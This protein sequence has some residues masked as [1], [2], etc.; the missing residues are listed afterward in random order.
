MGVLT[1]QWVLAYNGTFRGAIEMA[2]VAHAT[3]VVMPE[4][5]P[6]APGPAPTFE[7]TE[8]VEPG[9]EATEEERADYDAARAEFEA[10]RGEYETALAEHQAATEA[11]DRALADYGDRQRL[12]RVMLRTEAGNRDGALASW[13]LL[14]ALDP[15]YASSGTVAKGIVDGTKI[16]DDSVRTLVRDNWN[17]VARG[18]R[19][20]TEQRRDHLADL[21]A[22]RGDRLDR[23]RSC[24]PPPTRSGSLKATESGQEDRWPQS[25]SGCQGREGSTVSDAVWIALIGQSTALLVALG[26]GLRFLIQRRDKTREIE[27]TEEIEDREKAEALKTVVRLEAEVAGLESSNAQL[28]AA[29]ATLTQA[30]VELATRGEEAAS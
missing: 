21:A 1:D 22:W 4:A 18:D 28:V 20:R 9:L 10:A 25:T 26:A 12:A 5:A 15:I 11:Y 30:I 7:M 23:H 16:P 13:A 19:D 2:A 17:R 3:N 29:N 14:G 8:P 27:A 24:S 6:Q